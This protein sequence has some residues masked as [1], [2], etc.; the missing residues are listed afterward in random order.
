MES[1][2]IKMVGVKDN[3]LIWNFKNPLY[4]STQIESIGTYWS[5]VCFKVTF[6]NFTP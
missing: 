5:A 4:S 6:S 2:E 3:K 1:K